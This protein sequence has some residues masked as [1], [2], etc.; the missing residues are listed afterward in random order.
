MPIGTRDSRHASSANI[1]YAHTLFSISAVDRALY[2][3]LRFP[4]NLKRNFLRRTSFPVPT[5]KDL[6]TR[7][8]R[9]E[10]RDGMS[11]RANSVTW[12]IQKRMASMWHGASR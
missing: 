2:E 4:C 8:R 6:S 9:E 10:S 12:N 3:A 5:E 1:N 7:S 11:R